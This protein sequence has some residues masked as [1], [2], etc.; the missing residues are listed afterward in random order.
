VPQAGGR[1]TL[2]SQG[3]AQSSACI[4]QHGYRAQQAAT[5]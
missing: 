2:G 3:N 5:K 1:R 4:W